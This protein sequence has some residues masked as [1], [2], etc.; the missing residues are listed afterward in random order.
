MT[1]DKQVSLPPICL[2]RRLKHSSMMHGAM[3]QGM[4]WRITRK[5]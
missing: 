5:P 2:R 3:Q 1:C 4:K